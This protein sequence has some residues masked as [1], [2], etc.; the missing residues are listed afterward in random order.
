MSD[1]IREVDE[2]YRRERILGFLSRFQIPL[3]ILVVAIMVGA[4]A[5]RFSKDRQTA[6]AE[7]D[8][9]RYAA[10]EALATAGKPQEAAKAFDE[11]GKTGPAGYAHLARLRVAAL[12]GA[13][14][15]EAGGQAY[16]SIANDES[17]DP[18][19]RDTARLRGAMLRVDVEKPADFAQRYGRF[20]SPGFGFHASMNELLALSAMK[21]GDYKAA[22]R[23]VDAI[24]ADMVAPPALRNRA[25]AWSALVAAGPATPMQ[26]APP[27]A[28]VEAIGSLTPPPAAVAPPA[29]PAAPSTPPAPPAAAPAPAA[30]PPPTSPK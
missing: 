2:D 5:W 9:V 26:G 30:P 28:R 10:A 19:M 16:D 17:F 1:F 22:G 8:N 15:P 14:D 12:L 11:I 7:A 6:A 27:P 4:G 29:T 3:A 18:S 21:G 20:T 25:Q 13:S 23:Y 24:L